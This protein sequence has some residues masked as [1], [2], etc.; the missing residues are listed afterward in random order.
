LDREID[1]FAGGKKLDVAIRVILRIGLYQLRHLD[2]V[3]AYSAINESVELARMAKRKSAA[4]F[5]NAIL[6]RATRETPQLEFADELDRIGVETSHPRWLLERWTD[7]F[8]QERAANI[9]AANNEIPK[10]FFRP[11]LNATVEDIELLNEYRD[12]RFDG[13]FSYS[14]V[15]DDLLDLLSR[16]AIYIQDAGSQLVATAVSKFIQRRFLDVCAS[17]GGKT[18]LIAMLL[19]DRTDV[20]LVAGDITKNRLDILHDSLDSQ[21][22]RN[23]VVRQYNAEK[24]LPFDRESLDTVFVDAPCSGTGTIRHNPEIRYRATEDELV[25]HSNRQLAILRNA[26]ELVS[27][28][29]TLVYSTCSLEIAENEKVIEQFLGSNNAYE[30][31]D[32]GL[33]KRFR[34]ELGHYRMWPDRDSCDGFFVAGLRRS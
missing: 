9:A 13:V 23:V 26:S 7:S 2:R 21:G 8:G 10:Q 14:T 20:E 32:V 16:G 29:G 3:P 30:L 27:A 18:G 17:P 5:V 12:A 28:G 6:R 15:N 31:C 4:G 34:T 33:D 25:R 1:R 22:C 19:K 11:T 24:D